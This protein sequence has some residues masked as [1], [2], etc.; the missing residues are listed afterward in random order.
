[1]EGTVHLRKEAET[2]QKNEV[3]GATVRVRYFIPPNPYFNKVS[4]LTTIF[5]YLSLL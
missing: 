1:M 2:H 3:V 5:A 4:N